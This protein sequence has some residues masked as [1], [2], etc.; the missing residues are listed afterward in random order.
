MEIRHQITLVEGLFGW[1]VTVDSTLFSNMLDADEDHKVYR[2]WTHCATLE[3][4]METIPG[5]VR[6]AQNEAEEF[7]QRY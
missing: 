3:S 5:L 2:A 7:D 4:G 6:I 1:S